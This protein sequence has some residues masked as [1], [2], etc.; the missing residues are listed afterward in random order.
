MITLSG[1]Q[2]FSLC[3]VIYVLLFAFQQK[4]WRQSELEDY[5]KFM[6]IRYN[7]NI[8]I[9]E[10]IPPPNP[11]DFTS[12]EYSFTIITAASSHHWCQLTNWINHINNLQPFLP[13]YINPRIIIYDLGL[14][15]QQRIILDALKLYEKFTEPRTFNFSKYPEFWNLQKNKTSRGEFG[16]KVGIIKEISIE[17]PGFLIWSDSGT[18]FSQKI[19]ENLPEILKL[20]N[21][22]IS[23]KSG[24][25]MDIWTHSGVYKYFNDDGSKYVNVSNCNAAVLF[26]DTKKTQYLID[27]WYECALEKECIAPWG[28]SRENHRQDQAILTYLITNDSRKCEIDKTDLGVKT[29]VF[30][31]LCSLEE[32]TLHSRNN[33]T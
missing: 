11:K 23:P 16:W 22:F 26:F 1:K 25:T 20:Y 31:H 12:D 33:H 18:L 30:D 21:G 8:S 24:G 28:S 19:F 15:E 10:V 29:H 13:K 17:F 14:D 27:A 6:N 4:F 9:F 3:M 5:D 7:R 32:K 2:I